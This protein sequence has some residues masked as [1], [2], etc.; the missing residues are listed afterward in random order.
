MS[1]LKSD[2]QQKQVSS[3]GGGGRSY[4][5]PYGD[6]PLNRMSFSGLPFQDRVS[7]SY[8]QLLE[9]VCNCLD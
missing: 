8:Y 9:R 3:P 6:V 4:I 2:C 1:A 7:L 5:L